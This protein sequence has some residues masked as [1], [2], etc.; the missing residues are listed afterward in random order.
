MAGYSK[1]PVLIPPRVLPLLHDLAQHMVHAGHTYRSFTKKTGT[2]QQ[3]LNDPK[4]EVPPL[5]TMS[6]DNYVLKFPGIE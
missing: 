3:A 6:E 2:P 4:V 1:S 5:L